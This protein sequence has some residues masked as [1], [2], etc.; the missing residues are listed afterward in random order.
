MEKDVMRNVLSQIAAGQHPSAPNGRY[1]DALITI[2]YVKEG[3]TLQLTAFGR[4]ILTI[5][6]NQ[7]W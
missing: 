6:Q 2:G 4:E 5:L 7:Q 1:V 3:W